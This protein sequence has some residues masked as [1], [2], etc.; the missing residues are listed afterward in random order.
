[1]TF[2][3]K[4][5]DVAGKHPDEV[6]RA[7][8]NISDMVKEIRAQ[9]ADRPASEFR[10]AGAWQVSKPLR[11][12]DA[13]DAD[14][15]RFLARGVK[16]ID[17][18]ESKLPLGLSQGQREVRNRCAELSKSMQHVLDRRADDQASGIRTHMDR[19]RTGP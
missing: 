6:W 18:L 17:G 3:P 7:V 13:P 12:G 9:L 11:F 15:Q 8:S 4:R 2:R 19:E 5:F 16:I 14:V 1:M 10:E